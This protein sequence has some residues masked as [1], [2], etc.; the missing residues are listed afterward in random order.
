MRFCLGSAEHSGGRR[1][2]QLPDCEK[3]V[4]AYFEIRALQVYYIGFHWISLV[5][6]L[7]IA[8]SIIVL[9]GSG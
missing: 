8:G 9:S 7:K 1:P 6:L 5:T 4:T 3:I 2:K